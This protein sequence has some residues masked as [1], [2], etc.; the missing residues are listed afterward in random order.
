LNE[1]AT[2]VA[3]RTHDIAHVTHL[4]RFRDA[5]LQREIQREDH[6]M[7][8]LMPMARTRNATIYEIER[9]K[10]AAIE[11][12]TANRSMAHAIQC[13]EKHLPRAIPRGTIGA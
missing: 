10:A 5:R 13:A 6:V 11:Q 8:V 9:A 3:D 7:R 1:P 2:A 4:A 12:L